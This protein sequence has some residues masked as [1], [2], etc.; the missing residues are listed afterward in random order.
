MAIP[1]RLPACVCQQRMGGFGMFR[2]PGSARGDGVESSKGGAEAQGMRQSL[3]HGSE[4]RVTPD[5][6]AETGY[7]YTLNWCHDDQPIFM[8]MRGSQWGRRQSLVMGIA[9]HP[10]LVGQPHRLRHLRIAL[11]GIAKCARHW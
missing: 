5:L 6:L 11:E 8:H 9:L 4:S 3:Q 1:Y 7:G 2:Q 10:Y